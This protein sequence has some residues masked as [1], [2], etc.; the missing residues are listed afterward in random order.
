MPKRSC[1]LRIY[2]KFRTV[3]SN[4]AAVA[5]PRQVA[6]VVHKHD[7]R[8]LRLVHAPAAVLQVLVDV[9]AQARAR[10]RQRGC[11]GALQAS[12][13]PRTPWLG[14]LQVSPTRRG[15]RS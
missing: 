5:A 10:R 3:M 1:M 13:G 15:S 12:E 14:H 11:R 9:P 7:V 6:V 4:G 2:A 8:V